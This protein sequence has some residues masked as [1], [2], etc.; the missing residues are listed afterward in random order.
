MVKGRKKIMRQ[1]R[2]SFRRAPLT[3]DPDSPSFVLSVNSGTR[4]E[5]E[6]S[7]RTASR[8][9]ETKCATL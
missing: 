3:S 7:G 1:R 5:G 9:G 2:F 6:P 8:E 4:S